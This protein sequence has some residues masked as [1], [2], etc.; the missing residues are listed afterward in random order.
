[1]ITLFVY[2][3]GVM[4]C[5]FEVFASYFYRLSRLLLKITN[6]VEILSI[7]KYQPNINAK[8]YPYFAHLQKNF[9]VKGYSQ[10]KLLFRIITLFIV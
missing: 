8:K 10:T 7:L 1:M 2:V 9:G 5:L 3:I 6:S 4:C